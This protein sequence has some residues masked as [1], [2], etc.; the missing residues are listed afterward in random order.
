MQAVTHEYHR[1]L[2]ILMLVRVEKS[3]VKAQVSVS[4]RAPVWTQKTVGE[5]LLCVFFFLWMLFLLRKD[6]QTEPGVPQQPEAQGHNWLIQ[7]FP[8]LQTAL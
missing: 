5:T 2:E 7:P 6:G 3:Q 8:P 1:Q 4:I